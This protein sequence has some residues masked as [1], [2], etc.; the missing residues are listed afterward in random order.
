MSATD[1]AVRDAK[2]EAYDCLA[3]VEMWTQRLRAANE[4]VAKASKAASHEAAKAEE[5]D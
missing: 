2:A 4:N 1:D 3:M 5:K